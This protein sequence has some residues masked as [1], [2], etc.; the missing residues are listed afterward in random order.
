MPRITDWRPEDPVAWS[1]GQSRTAWRNLAVSV[2]ALLAAFAVWMFWS[3]LAVR[4]KDAGFPFTPAQLFT[5]IS[6]A[7]LSGATLRIPSSFLVT[8]A[9]GRNTVAVTTALLV[10][11][12]L[13]AGIAL[14]DTRTS[15]TTFAVL[16]TLSGIGGGNF[17]SSMANIPGFFPR[18]IAGT[19]P[20]P[21]RR[22]GQPGGERH[23][24]PDPGGDRHGHVRHAGRRAADHLGRQGP[25]PGQRRPG[26]GAHRR[27][28]GGAGLVLHGQPA[29][30]G[31]RAPGPG[32]PQDPRP[33]HP[34]PG[35]ERRGGGPA[36]GLQAGPAGPGGRAARAPSCSPWACCA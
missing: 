26:L 34:G 2:P 31:Q 36:A 33:A 35:R 8:L 10:I 15:F 4:M 20:G 23:A 22:P 9:G 30:P 3:I 24:V 25:L 11:P 18:R 21:Q 6:I 16:A 32:H 29:R 14:Q 1:G 12:A 27:A 13:G 17:A 7:G 19:R 5:L 28:A